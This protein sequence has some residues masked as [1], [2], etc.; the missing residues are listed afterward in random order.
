MM[1]NR[2]DCSRRTRQELNCH[3]ESLGKLNTYLRQANEKLV[4][5]TFDARARKS[6]AEAA[7]TLQQKFLAMLAHELR[8][9]LAPI[10]LASRMLTKIPDQSP[11]LIRIQEIIDRQLSSLTRLLDDLLDAARVESGKISIVPLPIILADVVA[12]AVELVSARFIER[13]QELTIVIPDD[14]IIIDGDA[15]RLA[16]VISNLLINSS[17]FTQRAGIISITVRALGDN[18]EITVADN[19]AGMAPELLPNIFNLF[20]Q[21]T[22]SLERNKGGLG[23]GLHLV[24]NIVELH[25]GSVSATSDGPGRGSVFTVLLPRTDLLVARESTSSSYKSDNENYR[26]LL[27]EDNR[28]ASDLLSMVLQSEGYLVTVE[29]DGLA[30]LAEGCKNHFDLLISD[31]GLPGIDGYELIRRLHDYHNAETPIAISISGYGQLED[32]RRALSAGYSC[33]LVKP[34]DPDKLLELVRTLPH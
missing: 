33:H 13:D 4:L 21:G 18:V 27:V 7:N 17:K 26:I 29:H 28:D 10:G 22:V 8:N 5:A 32:K 9:P 16:Q 3:Y 6:D 2:G 20:T 24:Q 23:I 1:N 14:E 15:I 30:A 11:E 12:N 25:G 34:V 19:G 31:I